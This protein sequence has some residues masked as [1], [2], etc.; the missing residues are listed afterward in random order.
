MLLKNKDRKR[1][2]I[3]RIFLS[4]PIFIVA[5]YLT[6]V[7]LNIM[8]IFDYNDYIIEFTSKTPTSERLVE[9]FYLAIYYLGY[10]MVAFFLLEIVLVLLIANINRLTKVTYPV[11]AILKNS[12]TYVIEPDSAFKGTVIELLFRKYLFAKNI[13]HTIEINTMYEAFLKFLKTNKR[14]KYLAKEFSFEDFKHLIKLSLRTRLTYLSQYDI[15]YL[16]LIKE[17]IELTDQYHYFKGDSLFPEDICYILNIS[18]KEL[19]I[20]TYFLI[21]NNNYIISKS[22]K[23]PEYC[24][25]F[26]EHSNHL[27]KGEDDFNYIIGE[28]EFSVEAESNITALAVSLSENRRKFFRLTFDP[29]TDSYKRG[30]S[31]VFIDN[32]EMNLFFQ[33]RGLQPNYPHLMNF[34]EET[35]GKKTDAIIY[36]PVFNLDLPVQEDFFHHLEEH[37]FK[38]GKG[39]LIILEKTFGSIISEKETEV[40]LAVDM[41]S[42]LYEGWCDRIYLIADQDFNEEGNYIGKYF[43]CIE[44]CRRFFEALELDTMEEDISVLR[45]EG[46]FADFEQPSNLDEVVRNFYRQLGTKNPFILDNQAKFEQEI[47]KYTP[48]F[49]VQ[50]QEGGKRVMLFVDSVN[51]IKG[52]QRFKK[53]RLK[54]LKR[55]YAF[56]RERDFEGLKDRLKKINKLDL[57]KRI[58]NHYKDTNDIINAYLFSGVCPLSHNRD[59]NRSDMNYLRQIERMGLKTNSRENRI[60]AGVQQEFGIDILMASYMIELALN[61]RYDKAI[62]ITGDADFS[63][64][65]RKLLD[66]NKD[67]EIRAFKSRISESMFNEFGSNKVRL[68]E[69]FLGF[70]TGE[71][72]AIIERYRKHLRYRED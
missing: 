25:F 60:I 42:L 55:T 13:F 61:D 41:I 4:I 33:N 5:L 11:R 47:R 66:L 21:Q 68:L 71:S 52:L 24:L 53:I 39:K 18:P 56:T 70:R 48:V 31:I 14:Y 46:I 17:L 59:F 15:Y 45:L 49:G 1:L 58:Y 10:T 35:Y 22:S 43:G 9:L 65:V 50:E 6:G 38:Y 64:V 27:L 40:A 30:R 3:Y 69:T 44:A 8:N 28:L 54:D 63:P 62:I 34:I 72:G 16:N 20:L 12:N 67:F 23:Y 32:V 7:F 19:E 29:K 26:Q 51:I 57:I 36:T 2:L 37:Q